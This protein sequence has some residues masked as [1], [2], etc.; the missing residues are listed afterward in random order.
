MIYIWVKYYT[1]CCLGMPSICMDS[2]DSV[3]TSALLCV[4][5]QNASLHTHL[6]GLLAGLILH[7]D[8]STCFSNILICLTLIVLASLILTLSDTVLK[9]SVRTSVIHVRY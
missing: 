3:C 5:P 7:R 4:N 6:K 2:L 1:D 9:R 8:T